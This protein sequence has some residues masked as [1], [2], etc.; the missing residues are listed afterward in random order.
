MHYDEAVAVDEIAI[1]DVVEANSIPSHMP[2]E[3]LD[4][5]EDNHVSAEDVDEV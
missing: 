3:P 2:P 1:P 5:R 4:N